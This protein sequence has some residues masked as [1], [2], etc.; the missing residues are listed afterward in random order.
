MKWDTRFK[1]LLLGSSNKL[2]LETNISEA[3]QKSVLIFSQKMAKQY[4]RLIMKLI[5]WKNDVTR[6]DIIFVMPLDNIIA[7][8]FLGV[9]FYVLISI[10]IIVL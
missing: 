4:C 2:C 1:A 5:N 9:C 8:I 6:N 7:T 3:T 10:F